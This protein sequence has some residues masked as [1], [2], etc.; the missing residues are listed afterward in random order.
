MKT[1]DQPKKPAAGSTDRPPANGWHDSTW[2]LRRGLE[3][4]ED[5]PFDLLPAEWQ[6]ATFNA[7]YAAG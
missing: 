7:Q 2:D 4:V 1:N 6:M 3:V 5:I